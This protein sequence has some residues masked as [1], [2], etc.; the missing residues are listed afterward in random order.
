VVLEKVGPIVL[1]MKYYRVGAEK[2]I[3]HK[4]K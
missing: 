3:L 1:K 2:C 4:I